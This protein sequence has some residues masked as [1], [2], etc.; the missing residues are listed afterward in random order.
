MSYFKAL[1]S[2]TIKSA[3]RPTTYSVTLMHLPKLK[4]LV[5]FGALKV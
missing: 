2:L 4:L 5:L 1:V 3:P